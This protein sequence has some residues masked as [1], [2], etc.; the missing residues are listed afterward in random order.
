M[1]IAIAL[2]LL[3]DLCIRATSL[4]AHYTELGVVPFNALELSYWKVGYFSLFQFC[5]TYAFALFV[6]IITGITYLFLLAGYKTRLVSLLSWLLL[7]SL[8]NRNTLILQGGDDLLRLILFWGIFLPWGNFYSVDYKLKKAYNNKK[9]VLSV[10]TLGYVILLF[11][12]YFFTGLLKTGAEWNSEGTA[13][14]YALSLDQMTWPLGK[15][16][17]S[18]QT[19]LKFLTVFVRWSEMLVPFLLFIPF[20]NSKFRM[21]FVLCIVVF[22]VSISLTLFV[23]LFYL[24]GLTTLIGLLP[25]EIMNWFDGK[26][27]H[28]EKAISTKNHLSF[29]AK[30]SA[31][32]YF[33]VIKNSFL[34]F[35]IALCMLWNVG[36]VNGSGLAVSDNF[37]TFG[38]GLR[39]NQSW[40]MFAPTVFKDD[41]WYVMEGTTN[42]SLK[43]DINRNG[44]KVDYTK[45]VSVLA[46]IKD[47]RWRKYYE[48]YL[49][50]YNDFMRPYLCNYLLVDWNKN[51]LG[52]KITA[53]KIIYMKE[54]SVLPNQKQM[55]TKEVLCTCGK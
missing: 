35:C 19:L 55:V 48:N 47:D 14:H 39:F 26:I 1:R 11:S 44:A 46:Y 3:T 9:T 2:I 30:I 10:A 41:G 17:L 8:Q 50:T 54:V 28:V 49:F 31:N 37:F 7:T 53:L 51:H 52:K 15:M 42:D 23:G 13:L 25:T 24:I 18:H 43:I 36:T 34:F 33:N 4:T 22:Q 21:L 27:N 38:Y 5:D 6:F 12:V 45:P 29:F 20:K 16:L 40:G 32:Y